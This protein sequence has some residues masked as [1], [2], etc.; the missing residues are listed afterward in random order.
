M[1][2]SIRSR[3]EAGWV[4]ARLRLPAAGL[5]AETR[6]RLRA[7]EGAQMKSVTLNAK[8]W[9]R[10]DAAAEVVIVPAGMGGVIDVIARY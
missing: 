10:F 8:P 6:L 1:S 2:F 4:E 7:W 3:A 9:R 5:R